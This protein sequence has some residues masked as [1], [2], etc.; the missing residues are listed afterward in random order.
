MKK[1][2]QKGNKQLCVD[3]SRLDEMLKAGFV[4]ID[5]KT[6]KPV[7]VEAEKSEEV[8][9]LELENA[10]LRAELENA[11]AEFEKLEAENAKLKKKVK[12]EKKSEE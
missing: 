12:D 6:G 4:E 3:E 11:K 5:Q 7:E 9:A 1:I 2:V 8:K 10:A